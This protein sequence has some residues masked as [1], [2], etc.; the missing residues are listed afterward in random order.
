MSV[1]QTLYFQ[2]VYG[3][4]PTAPPTGDKNG[5]RTLPQSSRDSQGRIMSRL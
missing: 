4:S 5:M 1:S 2:G 3:E